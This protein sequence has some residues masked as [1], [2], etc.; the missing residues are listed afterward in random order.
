MKESIYLFVFYF[1]KLFNFKNVL[2]FIITL[3]LFLT[4]YKSI[5]I[6][7]F[8]QNTNWMNWADYLEDF[9]NMKFFFVA[10]YGTFFSCYIYLYLKK[11]N[12][13]YI[14]NNK[15]TF[16]NSLIVLTFLFFY[17]IIFYII[18]LISY[19]G[20]FETVFF[21]EILFLSFFLIL[22]NIC[23]IFFISFFNNNKR[24][25]ADGYLFL[26]IVLIINLITIFLIMVFLQTGKP[27]DTIDNY[28][29]GIK[30][31]S[32]ILL[33]LIILNFAKRIYINK[34]SLVN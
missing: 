32:I 23:S 3:L 20:Y 33:V 25:K 2:F 18:Y 34:K 26:I 19:I 16:I 4:L 13:S 5:N 15:N 31:E 7:I 12:F 11:I 30:I 9:W 17:Y 28:I 8:H 29:Y 1:K 10:L 14:N 24:E 21:L 27:E 22:F 6:I